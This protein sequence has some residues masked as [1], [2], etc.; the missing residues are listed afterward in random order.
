[1]KVLLTIPIDTEAFSLLR[2]HASVETLDAYTRERLMERVA[3]AEILLVRLGTATKEKIDPEVIDRGRR[4]KMIA[5][6][7]AGYE[8]VDVAYAT[9]KGILVTNTAG[10]NAISVAEFTFGLLLSVARKFY[11]VT[12]AVR[13][14]LSGWSQLQGVE[15]Y[16]KTMG[17]IGL[18]HIG[19]AVSKIAQAFGMKI[20][21]YHPR[22]SA[23]KIHDPQITFVD[24]QRLLQESDVV[25]IHAPLTNETEGLIGSKEL[26][27]MKK[28]AI[29]LNTA[30]GKIIDENALIN[31][32]RA[33][34][35]AAAGLDVVMDDP[36]KKGNP[37]LQ[38][39]NALV[40][41]NRAAKTCEAQKRNALWTVED[42][43]RVIHGERPERLVNPE[44][45]KLISE[46]A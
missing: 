1:M 36:V 38:F 29:L 19:R 34:Q 28:T 31:A 41:P 8:S 17:I 13:S 39:E 24:L 30:R 42:I 43:V 40:M 10:S 37:L 27:L 15:L 16:G 25:S 14:G 4:L 44:V 23:K 26:G 33:K 32:L 5:R 7:G 21:A 6:H 11:G 46:N 18:G 20:I 35:I 2:Q 12:T 45:L 22:P 3:D 9:R